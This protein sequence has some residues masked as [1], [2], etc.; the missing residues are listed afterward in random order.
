MKQVTFKSG[1]AC[2][3]DAHQQSG[4]VRSQSGAAWL[5]GGAHRRNRGSSGGTDGGR[6]FGSL[7]VESPAPQYILSASESE[8]DVYQRKMM[9]ISTDNDTQLLKS[10]RILTSAPLHAAPPPTTSSSL[11]DQINTSSVK[12]WAKHRCAVASPRRFDMPY[13]TVPISIRPYNHGALPF[14]P[15]HRDAKIRTP[16]TR[17]TLFKRPVESNCQ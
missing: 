2:G 11:R 10:R 6:G 16:R 5:P 17:L 7:S 12:V 3:G 8:L 9:E 4:G 15:P 14:S 1:M 13:R